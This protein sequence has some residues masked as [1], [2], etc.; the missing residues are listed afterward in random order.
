MS[1][2][3]DN[4]ERIIISP[5]FKYYTDK[6]IWV[7]YGRIVVYL[8][9]LQVKVDKITTS[10]RDRKATSG[11]PRTCLENKLSELQSNISKL[12]KKY[13]Q[14]LL[15]NFPICRPSLKNKRMSLPFGVSLFLPCFELDES[16]EKELIK[17]LNVERVPHE[18][19]AIPRVTG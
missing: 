3:D 19:C 18:A 6:E 7:C 17:R 16:E 13:D 5:N 14:I 12:E 8:A 2:L 1:K 9:K 10:L 11:Y 15:P 4:G